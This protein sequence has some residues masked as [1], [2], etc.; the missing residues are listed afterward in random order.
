MD[1][2][3]VEYAK[4]TDRDLDNIPVYLVAQ[5]AS[6]RVAFKF[7]ATLRAEINH[8]NIKTLPSHIFPPI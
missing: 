2:Y 8:I 4:D 3:K 6:K 7:V 1:Y 5:S